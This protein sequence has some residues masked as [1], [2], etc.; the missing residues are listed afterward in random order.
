MPRVEEDA[1]RGKNGVPDC[2]RSCLIIRISSGSRRAATEST[3]CN[4]PLVE[5]LAFLV[6]DP[7]VEGWGGEAYS[8]SLLFV[9]FWVLCWGYVGCLCDCVHESKQFW[10]LKPSFW[11]SAC[12]P[13]FVFVSR[14]RKAPIRPGM[15]LQPA[16][17]SWA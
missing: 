2:R 11:C 12:H 5:M 3:G 6:C 4:S 1:L 15:L 9:L 13:D 10:V 8:M 7:A 17:V 16:L 14:E